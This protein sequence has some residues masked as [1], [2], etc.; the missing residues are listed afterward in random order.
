VSFLVLQ[1]GVGCLANDFKSEN[2]L[3]KTSKAYGGG[4]D[5][6]RALVPVERRRRRRRRRRQ[7]QRLVKV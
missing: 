6:Y 3:F 1:V 2:L 5:P 4:Q 7:Q